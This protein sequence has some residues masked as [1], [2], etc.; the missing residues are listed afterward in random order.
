MTTEE[1]ELLGLIQEECAE[2]IQIISKVRRF[3]FDSYNP[4]DS[5]GK[6]NH[7]L[8]TDEIGD[9]EALMTLLYDRG[10]FDPAVVRERVAWK[11]G[12][13]E[14]H[15]GYKLTKP[16]ENAELLSGLEKTLSFVQGLT[17]MGEDSLWR[18]AAAAVPVVEQAISKLKEK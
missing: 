16:D 4:Y 3:G 13:L 2:I 17:K 18:P 11:L 1:L 7:T 8:T 15:W 10:T 9:F 5:S 6:S 12:K 14:Q